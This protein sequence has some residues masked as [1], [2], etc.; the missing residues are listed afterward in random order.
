MG[1]RSEGGKGGWKGT[2]PIPLLSLL[3]LLKDGASTCTHNQMPPCPLLLASSLLLPLKGTP[4]FI[5]LF[6]SSNVQP[7]CPRKA[8]SKGSGRVGMCDDSSVQLSPC[9]TASP[10]P[11]NPL[12]PPH[13]TPPFPSTPSPFSLHGVPFSLHGAAL[14]HSHS[15]LL[16]PTSHPQRVGFPPLFPSLPLSGSGPLRG[17]FPQKSRSAQREGRVVWMGGSSNSSIEC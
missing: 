10:S 4:A 13:P 9:S 11:I 12:P 7:P 17:V 6:P 8:K 16:I 3:C 14:F 5:D 1:G 15:S 2:I